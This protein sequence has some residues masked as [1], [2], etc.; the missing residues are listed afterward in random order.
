MWRVTG[1]RAP[2]PRIVR[3]AHPASMTSLASACCARGADRRTPTPAS[4]ARL[5]HVQP[6]KSARPASTA[7]VVSCSRLARRGTT[8]PPDLRLRPSPTV[9]MPITTAQ[10]APPRLLKWTLASTPSP[11]LARRGDAPASSPAPLAPCVATAGLWRR[12]AP[13]MLVPAACSPS[14]AGLVSTRRVT[15]P[16]LPSCG[17]TTTRTAAS[18][19]CCFRTQASTAA[20]CWSA[21]LLNPRRVTRRWVRPTRQASS[22]RSTWPPTPPRL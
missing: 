12:P 16:R 11:S 13:P 2:P 1:A 5:P 8:A 4:C 14:R 10:L 19:R 15:A 18:G 20:P 9:G 21:R 6:S 22:P 3:P 17:A 7:Q